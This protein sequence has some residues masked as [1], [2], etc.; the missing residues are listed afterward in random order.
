MRAVRDARRRREALREPRVRAGRVRERV[1][2]RL[3]GRV[4]G[5]ER[6]QREQLRHRRLGL[7]RRRESR[8]QFAPQRAL[9]G[10]VAPTEREL[11]HADHLG[12]PA[13]LVVARAQQGEG[14][15]ADVGLRF[16]RREHALEQRQ[17]VGLF[18]RVE[19]LARLGERRGG[20]VQPREVAVRD[21]R[22]QRRGL[23]RRDARGDA[24]RPQAD[25]RLEALLAL[26]EPL[27][28]RE[29]LGVSRAR[30]GE[31]LQIADRALGIGREVLRDVG[32]LGQ[33]LEATRGR[34]CRGDGA[35]VE[36]EELREARS[37]G[38]RDGE[39]LEREGRR[40]VDLEHAR[41]HADERGRV[42]AEPLGVEAGG[43]LAEGERERGGE[44]R[45]EHGDEEIGD[46]V[47]PLQV[48]GAGLERVPALGAVR[49]GAR[50]GEALR[51]ARVLRGWGVSTALSGLAGTGVGI[52]DPLASTAG[53]ARAGRPYQRLRGSDHVEFPNC[54][55]AARG[56]LA[57]WVQVSR[58]RVPRTRRSSRPRSAS[59]VGTSARSSRG[60]TSAPG[61]PVRGRRI[62]CARRCSSLRCR[63]SRLRP[64]R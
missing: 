41:Q 64:T 60:S 6:E 27:E 16:R 55:A 40:G 20:V 10:A 34:R 14:P 3:R 58:L 56:T 48:R 26:E 31:L 22:P 21:A 28:R 42:V 12:L 36:R 8:A 44:L 15:L 62:A 11:E 4:V 61:P 47:G 33:Q 43:P 19:Q 54:P 7:T 49:L 52:H 59:T 24:R 39:P 25:Q 46:L 29:D 51:E 32:G 17:R 50:V 23:V 35:I 18:A 9:L 57:P 30:V 38:E 1:K 5:R 63:R 37:G 53:T 13:L 2:L 45:L